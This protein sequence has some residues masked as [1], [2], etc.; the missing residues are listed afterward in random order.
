MIIGQKIIFL[1]G[2]DWW[3]H[4]PSSGVQILQE[5]SRHENEC[6]YIN[7]IPLRM[8][9]PGKR[10]SWRRYLN[11]IKS[12]SMFLRKGRDRIWVLTPVFLPFF[13]T[14]RRILGINE[15]L[16]LW[17]IHLAKRILGWGQS[18]PII[19]SATPSA[20]ILLPRLK[21]KKASIY[22][23]CDKYDTYRDISNRTLIKTLDKIVVR[24]SDALFCTSKAI[25]RLYVDL[26]PRCYYVPH[27]YDP[28]FRKVFDDSLN[29]P[30]EMVGLQPPIIGYF[31]SLT[32]SNDQDILE[33]CAIQ[34]PNWN[35]VLIGELISDFS[36][37]QRLKN[38]HF[39][40]KKPI[41]ELPSYG[42]FFDVCI[43]NW[44]MNEWMHYCSPVKTK[45][46]LAM[47]KPVVS[48]PIPEVVDT[49]SDLISIAAT[50]A[51]FL[52]KIEWELKNDSEIR[53]NRRIAK[54]WND[55]W[56]QKV[57]EISDIIKALI[58]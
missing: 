23:L 24:H 47:G 9:H 8:P 40:G 13:G 17:Q 46:Y 11:K 49:F 14:K 10:A 45:E 15:Y 21:N 57:R 44:K 22:Y 31:G 50:P 54:V 43:M 37:L 25:Y 41:K 1:G 28:V 52:Q 3:T 18:R 55:T 4:P 53:R 32:E 48:I 27:G 7:H 26:H 56:D 33:Y 39:L 35:F 34:R 6:L 2:S 12:F 51:E 30:R 38:V 5:L 36:R 20:A 42:K 29:R 58:Q 16:L 19:I